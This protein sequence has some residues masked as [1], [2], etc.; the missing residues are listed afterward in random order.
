LAAACAVEIGALAAVVHRPALERDDWRSA[1]RRL[2]R[3]DTPLAIV[4]DPSYQR[5]VIEVYRPE[6]HAMPRAGV[7]VREI[8]FLGFARLPL[9]FRP[10]MGFKFLEERRIQHIALV[11]YQA[12]SPHIV[13]PARLAAGGGFS[14]SG[15]LW[16][17]H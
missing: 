4:T 11:R 3:G 5:A 6:V 17:P 1:T 7:S 8:A 13:R 16:S 2:G 14:A 10:P 15:V 9:A 12:T